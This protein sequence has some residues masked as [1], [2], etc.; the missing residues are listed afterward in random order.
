MEV[1]HDLDVEAA[2]T[3]DSLGLAF[4]RAA[5]PGSHP[6]FVSMLTDLVRERLALPDDTA[7]DD[8]APDNPT[9]DNPTPDNP[10]PDSTDLDYP[11]LGGL[12][13]PSHD[14]PADC[15]RYVRGAS[16]A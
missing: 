1:R 5:T 9:P 13:M 14:C 8:T 16:R 2:E 12:G 3:A 7:S 10:E 4:A 11:A 6:A 15:C